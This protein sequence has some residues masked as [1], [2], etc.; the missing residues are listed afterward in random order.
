MSTENAILW[1]SIYKTVVSY[2]YLGNKILN[3][4][5]TGPSEWC[6]HDNERFIL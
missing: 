3:S 4:A 1:S 2:E 5:I 6:R